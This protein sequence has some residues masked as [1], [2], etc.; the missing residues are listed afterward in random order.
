MRLLLQEQ[1]LL[2]EEISGLSEIAITPEM[3][4]SMTGAMPGYMM[5]R[6][7]ESNLALEMRRCR[8]DEDCLLTTMQEG[9]RLLRVAAGRPESERLISAEEA[10]ALEAEQQAGLER[11]R[12]EAEEIA[13]AYPVE[14]ERARSMLAPPEDPDAVQ[15]LFLWRNPEPEAWMAERERRCGKDLECLAD[16][17]D[18]ERLLEVQRRVE[19]ERMEA[20][21]EEERR[22]QEERAAA[23]RQAEEARRREEQ[24]MA[25]VERL[26]SYNVDG[27]LPEGSHLRPILF[28]RFT[29]FDRRTARP[30]AE[31]LGASARD[32]AAF[33]GME[34][35]G[36]GLESGAI[37]NRRNLI[38]AA[39]ALTRKEELGFCGDPSVDVYRRTVP[40]S[41]FTIG[42]AVV[43]R[44]AP[45]EVYVSVPA[46]FARFV[47][48][49][50]FEAG[51]D[52]LRRDVRRLA[53]CRSPVRQVLE[54]NLIAYALDREP[55][56]WDPEDPRMHAILR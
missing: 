16:R 51:D 56:P 5:A 18:L 27:L 4:L 53:T 31:A 9:T 41:E 43:Q 17:T 39:Y 40:G 22:A 44:Y 35:L 7:L 36:M 30:F 23:E 47:E 19:A 42:G 26:S 46:P 11:L 12:Q 14:W 24:R 29:I 34:G 3:Q 28:G 20:F 48:A 49:S 13:A 25:L 50:P 33:Y 1:H 2:R 32:S 15:P 45:A 52:L 21:A 55:I 37:E 38:V 54:H 8:G 6:N 10:A